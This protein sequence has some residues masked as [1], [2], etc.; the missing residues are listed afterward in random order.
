MAEN[1]FDEHFSSSVNRREDRDRDRQKC[2]SG[3]FSPTHSAHGCLMR[4]SLF[5]LST[6]KKAK[7]VRFY[8]N[9]DRFFK[10]V[11]YAVSNERFRSIES[12]LEE[13]TK[14]LVD[15][16]NL[17]KGVRFI[18]TV[19]GKKITDLDQLEEGE[20][21]VCS[22]TE[23][24]KKLD[25]GKNESP[26]W[27]SCKNKSSCSLKLEMN[28]HQEKDFIR[29]KLVTV[30]RNGI[31]P[32]K[33]VRILLNKKTAHSFGQVL[34]DITEAIKLD[35]GIVKKIFT[36]DG[37]P[38]NCLADFFNDDSIFI[39]YGPEK[40]SHDDFD[41]DSDECKS[42][43]PCTKSPIMQRSTK[44]S[45][46]LRG[47]QFSPCFEN[48]NADFNGEIYYTNTSPKLHRKSRSKSPGQVK[49]QNG[50]LS[51]TQHNFPSDI[52]KNY[53]VGKIIGDGNFAVVREC[54]DKKTRKEFALKIIDKTKCKG[55]EQM[56]EN[57]VSILR[58]VHHSNIVLLLEEYDLDNE[59]YLVMELLKGGDLFDAIAGATKYTERDASKMINNLASALAYL[60]SR[61]IVHRDIKPENL[62]VFDDEN[63]C[64]SLKLGDFGLAV[65][66]NESHELLY[67]VCGTPTYV[68]PEI[69]AET[70]YGKKVD[71][72]A[73]GVIMY[74]LLCG[75]P[76]FVSQT[77]N[78]D[79]L[80]DQILA[81]RYEFTS[82]Y[83]D[84]ISN[85]AKELI[86]NLL[87]VDV[88]G[89]FSAVQ[90]ISHPWVADDTALDNDMH[91]TVSHELGVYFDT[92][93]KT[94]SKSAGIALVAST[95]LD[96]G[97]QYFPSRRSLRS[98]DSSPS[99]HNSLHN[100]NGNG[101]H[102]KD[103]AETF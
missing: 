6:E 5:K 20:A 1:G 63:G 67:T 99:T 83:W 61:N 74:I 62:L 10:G 90:T 51:L 57:E 2:R 33:A 86:V 23:A 13:L 103:D 78:Q 16:A 45:A 27:N 36:L 71:M 93:P 30:I 37:K 91:E 80:F 58:R 75:F 87:Q 22:S 70:G 102:Y 94:S 3:R 43:T 79:E 82:P 15:Q 77:N 89:R 38:V 17:P 41:L 44:M 59:L 7:K 39:A 95:A 29:P 11:V 21:Y 56:I 32:R 48:E 25:Y 8:R 40:Y 84:D 35:S 49:F 68:A 12:L 100:V 50:H 34:G 4:T 81:G 18:F 101:N 98:G 96:K 66:I 55:K 31:K 42:L 76:P 92:K 88:D 47:R 53:D 60:H 97:Q 46:K 28:N 9:G 69:L 14:S 85:S 52:S 24:V 19:D 72:W 73:T 54:I 64:K 26:Q 65:E